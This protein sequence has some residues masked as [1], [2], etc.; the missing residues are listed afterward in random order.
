M[1]AFGVV[2]L[3]PLGYCL[4]AMA[5]GAALCAVFAEARQARLFAASLSVAAVAALGAVSLG[6]PAGWALARLGGRLRNGLAAGL[7]IPAL[8]PGYV[9]ATAW[10]D[11]LGP[12]GAFAQ[13]SRTLGL[14]GAFWPGQ[15][16]VAS[17]FVL[18]MSYFPLVALTAGLSVS[19]L[20][21]RHIETARLAAGPWRTFRG[22]VLP[23]VAPAIFEGALLVF[24]LSLLAFAVPSL[25]LTNVYPVEIYERFSA[26]AEPGAAVAQ[27]L[28]LVAMML[29][30]ALA[31][32]WFVR[33][34]RAWL[35]GGA[36]GLPTLAGRLARLL[37]SG[38][39]VALIAFSAGIP[40]AVLLA[41]ARPLW[42]LFEAWSTA[43]EEIV[44]SVCM[45]AVGA[46]LCVLLGLCMALVARAWRGGLVF[47]AC[48]ACFLISG[49]VLGVGL[50]RAWNHAGWRG[51]V[52][53]SAFIMPLAC[54][55]RYTL[56]PWIGLRA[57]LRRFDAR[58]EEAAH[59]NGVA[60]W[61]SL[62]G[63]TLPL[64]S[65]VLAGLWGMCFVLCMG[66]LDTIV[67]VCPPGWLPISVRIFS[68]M[69]YG[70][71]RLVAALALVNTAAILA[72]L[73][74]TWLVG[75]WLHHRFSLEK[76][77]VRD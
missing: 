26:A 46:T 5:D 23:L 35:S 17:G 27:A 32:R 7:A 75:R 43:R 67:L 36:R 73:A 13:A 4:G 31:W 41:R 12:Q 65:P 55:A 20:D 54:A 74:L 42:S 1:A 6:A 61:R 44:T 34:R 68:L 57:A 51:A 59:A 77:D 62:L 9:L 70:P 63:V 21:A 56:V 29:P 19:R 40:A 16:P 10:G 33:P 76:S 72:A 39:C 53:D 45:A 71:S 66:E 22:I 15:G 2:C 3:L 38:Y 18:A 11:V 49:P 24:L 48:V 28:P 14:G 60:P 52:Y 8:L 69:H 58:L 37:A 25:M 64:L 50:I 30:L 47:W